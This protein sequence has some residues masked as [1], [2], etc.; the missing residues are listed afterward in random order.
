MRIARIILLLAIFVSACT[1]NPGFPSS[2]T[3]VSENEAPPEYISSQTPFPTQNSLITRN[4]TLIADCGPDTYQYENDTSPDLNWKTISCAGKERNEDSYFKIFNTKNGKEWFINNSDIGS[5]LYLLNSGWFSS[6]YWTKDGSFLYISEPSHFS[7]CCWMGGYLIVI[8]FNL[9][10]GNKT[11]LVNTLKEEDPF[12]YSI[13][14]SEKFFLYISM[15]QLHIL[16]LINWDERIF[17]LP[18]S[19]AGSGLPLMSGD[20]KK[21][22]FMQRNWPQEYLGDSTYGSLSYINFE[23]G[24]IYKLLSDYEFFDTPRPL[25]W[26]DND[27]VLLVNG[28]SYFLINTRTGEFSKTE[29]P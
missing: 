22:I 5:N 26:V 27:T 16:N 11:I 18:E 1:T 9:E 13:S 25:R 20:E 2:H 6:D 7:G 15:D 21:V 24:K 19:T 8:L 12:D 28:N 14:S 10:T 23:N 29:K 17:N 3:S 4:P